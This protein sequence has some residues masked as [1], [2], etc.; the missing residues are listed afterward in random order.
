MLDG[1]NGDC[2]SSTWGSSVRRHP[3]S[4]NPPF[5]PRSSAPC[6][7]HCFLNRSV[8]GGVA[9]R[10]SKFR[11]YRLCRCEH[12]K[13]LCVFWLVLLSLACAQDSIKSIK[14]PKVKIKKQT[15][16]Q[17]KTVNNVGRTCSS[18]PLGEEAAVGRTWAACVGR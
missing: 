5:R 18:R 11:I 7:H 17:Q 16:W 14:K 3:R 9:G 1:L 10:E 15:H 2:G 13:N 6:D 4:R 12:N 8:F